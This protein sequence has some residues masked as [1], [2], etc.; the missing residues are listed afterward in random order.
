MPLEGLGFVETL[1]K[2][3]IILQKTDF[4]K[5]YMAKIDVSFDSRSEFL[6]INSC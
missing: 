4:Y 3:E 1:P 6:T 2:F 5:I